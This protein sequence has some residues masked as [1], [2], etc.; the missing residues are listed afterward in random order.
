VTAS[1]LTGY[2]RLAQTVHRRLFALSPRRTAVSPLR[3]Q[4]SQRVD[5]V[6]SSWVEVTFRFCAVAKVL[7]PHPYGCYESARWAEF[8]HAESAKAVRQLHQPKISIKTVVGNKNFGTLA[9]TD[10][11]LPHLIK[12]GALVEEPS[13]SFN[14]SSDLHRMIQILQRVLKGAHCCKRLRF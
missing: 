7:T 3:L 9:Y 13:G 1:G 6:S 10:T 12:S 11:V 8:P 4:H 2:P 5:I 14:S